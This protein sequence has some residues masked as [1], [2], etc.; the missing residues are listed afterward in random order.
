M[1]F[2][3]KQLAI[4]AGVLLAVSSSAFAADAMLSTG[5]YAHQLQKMEMMK[6]LDADG[7][8]MVT[9]TKQMPIT[10]VFLMHLTKMVMTL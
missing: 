2:Q 10:T 4:A 9:A 6:M 8:H 5:G 7:N 1:N 3:F